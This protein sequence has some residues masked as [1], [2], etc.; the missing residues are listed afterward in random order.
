MVDQLLAAGIPAMQDFSVETANRGRQ[1]GKHLVECPG[2]QFSSPPDQRL[3]FFPAQLV[4]RSATFL[5]CHWNLP[6]LVSQAGF[7]H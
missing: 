3:D 2:M 1:P 7:D 6:S 5:G 4:L